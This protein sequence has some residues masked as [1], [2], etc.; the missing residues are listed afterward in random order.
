MQQWVVNYWETYAPVVNWISVSSLLAIASIHEFPS[1]SID[2]VISFHQ[3]GLDV[4]VFM[5]IPLLMVVD[6]NRG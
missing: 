5:D 3:A 4:D 2:F 1:R 6:R